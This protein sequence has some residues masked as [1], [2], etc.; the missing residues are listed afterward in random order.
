[1]SIVSCISE[2]ASNLSLLIADAGA[3]REAT[4]F[5]NRVLDLVEI[6]VKTQAT[7]PLIVRMIIPLITLIVGTGQ[8]EKQLSD[9][10]HGLLRSRVGKLKE[11]PEIIDADN[12][13]Q[14]LND[15][16]SRAWK[17]HSSDVLAT[18][19]QCSLY[20]SRI[21]SHHGHTASILKAY[22][23]SLRDFASRKGSALN[24]NFFLDFT[25]RHTSVAWGFRD[26]ILKAQS[27]ATNAYRR[28]Q[29]FLLLQPLIAQLPVS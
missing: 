29:I 13:V 3:Q 27:E 21:L 12:V 4:H 19:S 26:A 2:R 20:L 7:S 25:R 15:V 17:V 22:D 5:K 24:S 23:T 10:A 14:V 6:F 1:M 9:K 11:V 16:H 28:C 18:L 8:D